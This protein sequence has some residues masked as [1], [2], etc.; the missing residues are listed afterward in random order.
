M[1]AHNC[2]F[3][4]TIHISVISKHHNKF[5]DINETLFKN[6]KYPDDAVLVDVPD[7]RYIFINRQHPNVKSEDT[8]HFLIAREVARLRLNATEV[9]SE[10]VQSKAI[11][12]CAEKGMQSVVEHGRDLFYQTHCITYDEYLLD[13]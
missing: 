6:P 12:M 4:P 2:V 8:V 7:G 9:E 1:I 3:D 11:E 13:N 10:R 5:D